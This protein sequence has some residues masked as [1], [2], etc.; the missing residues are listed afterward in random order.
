MTFKRAR[1]NHLE[2]KTNKLSTLRLSRV[3]SDYHAIEHDVSLIC[4]FYNAA[5]FIISIFSAVWAKELVDKTSDGRKK[6][7]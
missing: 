7:T 6:K 5:S 4:F 2:A 3:S 1:P